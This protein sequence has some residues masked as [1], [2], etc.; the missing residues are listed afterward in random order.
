MCERGATDNL[1]SGVTKACFYDPA[2]NLTYGDIATIGIDLDRAVE[3]VQYFGGILALPT[4]PI[5]EH[6]TRWRRA[7]PA[8]VVA[9]N[10]LKIAR[11][12]L[13]TPRIQNRGGGFVRCPAGDCA[14]ICRE[15]T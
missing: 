13:A 14:A 5:M 11:F 15:G 6:H 12:R 3:A 1:K 10:G 8:A 7:I 2:I 9:Q 4:R